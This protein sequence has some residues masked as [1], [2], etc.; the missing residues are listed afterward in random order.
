M[1]TGTQFKLISSIIREMDE[2]MCRVE[3]PGNIL[4]AVPIELFTTNHPKTQIHFSHQC[5][6]SF[7][8]NPTWI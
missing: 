1:Y 8:L 6:R 3:N 4:H 5:Q 7:L 2:V